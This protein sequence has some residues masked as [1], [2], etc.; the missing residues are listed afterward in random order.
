MDLYCPICGEPW[1]FD[2]LHEEAQA[3][4]S[5]PY[6]IVDSGRGY[7]YLAKQDKVKNPSWNSDDYQK[8][9]KKVQHDFQTQGCKALRIAYGPQDGCRKPTESELAEIERDKT[10]GLTRAEASSALYDILGDD[11]DGAAAMLEDMG[12]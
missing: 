7:G 4:Y 2:S 5:I 6:Y 10:F 11:M 1:D 3:R 12:F 9:F 8:V